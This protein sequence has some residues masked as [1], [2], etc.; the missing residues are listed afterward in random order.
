MRRVETRLQS[1]TST[2]LLGSSL[3]STAIP[4]VKLT[5]DSTH[6][7]IAHRETIRLEYHVFMAYN[8]LVSRNINA[9]FRETARASHPLI[10]P[11]HFEGPDFVRLIFL[12]STRRHPAPVQCRVRGFV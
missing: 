9:L 2:L 10:T 11:R 12:C 1:C 3:S 5:V 4:Q 7:E 8:S 6:A